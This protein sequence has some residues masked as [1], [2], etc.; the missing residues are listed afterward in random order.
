MLAYSILATAVMIALGVF[1]ERF[2]PATPCL[3]QGGAVLFP[4]NY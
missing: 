2:A 3:W 1:A 4:L